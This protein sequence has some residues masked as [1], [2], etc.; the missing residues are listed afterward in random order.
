MI[1][2]QMMGVTQE[3]IK[4]RNI[5]GDLYMVPTS[6]FKEKMKGGTLIET[7]Y[8]KEVM[9][10][11]HTHSPQVWV[12]S[13]PVMQSGSVTPRATDV[14]VSLVPASP[15]VVAVVLEDGLQ[16]VLLH[17]GPDLAHHTAVGSS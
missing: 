4:D 17:A 15:M 10:R 5:G 12:A 11:Q 7:Q 3:D 14:G 8:T 16:L 6:D 1:E 9:T 2:L 13:V